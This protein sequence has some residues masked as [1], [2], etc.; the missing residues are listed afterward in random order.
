MVGA[1]GL[2]RL[3]QIGRLMKRV[4]TLTALVNDV[5]ELLSELKD[6]HGPEVQ[7]LR[8]RVEDALAPTKRAIRQQS[9]KATARLGRYA[10]TVDGYISD[11][12]RLAFLT[13]ACIFGTIGY[14]AGTMARNRD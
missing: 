2:R 4:Q 5:E 3:I 6:Q 7:A 8:H 1:G 14:L 9:D 11:Y 13:G 12:P 10:S